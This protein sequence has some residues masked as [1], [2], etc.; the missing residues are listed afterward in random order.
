MRAL[1][2]LCILWGI[3]ALSSGYE[4]NELENFMASMIMTFQLQS[5][6]IIFN[7]NLPSLCMNHQWLLCISNQQDENELKIHL[8]YIHKGKK[9]DGL[10]FVGTEGHQKL[11]HYLSEVA[12]SPFTS[13]Y[14]TFMPQ[15]FQNDIQLPHVAP[16]SFR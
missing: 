6:T 13:N 9:Q 5:P 15:S 1:L 12:S 4:S 14:P 10:I 3:D 16:I 8:D 7:E 2:K 11:I